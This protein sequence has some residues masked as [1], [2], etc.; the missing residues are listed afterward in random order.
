MPAAAKSLLERQCGLYDKISLWAM[1][2]RGH[3]ESHPP[4][5]SC[6]LNNVRVPEEEHSPSV[7]V[8]RGG[9]L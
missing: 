2:F 9:V 5:P 6:K 7:Q 3:L 8:L 4:P 1:T